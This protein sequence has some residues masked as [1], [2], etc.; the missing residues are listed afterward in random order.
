M[1]IKQN[2]NKPGGTTFLNVRPGEEMKTGDLTVVSFN[3]T[4]R[5]AISTRDLAFDTFDFYNARDE[6]QQ[7]IH[8]SG[9]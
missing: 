6:Q 5:N 3:V 4:F 8:H 7:E 2:L 9:F 1:D